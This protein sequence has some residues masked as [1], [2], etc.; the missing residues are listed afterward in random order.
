MATFLQLRNYWVNIERITAVEV[1]ATTEGE[2]AGCR[3]YFA[4]GGHRDFD[5][6]QTRL[7]LEF[8]REHKAR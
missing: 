4:G 5:T 2:P 3:V 6:E 7:L 1:R 8:L